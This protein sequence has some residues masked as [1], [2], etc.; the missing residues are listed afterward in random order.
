MFRKQVFLI[1]RGIVYVIKYIEILGNY[2]IEFLLILL[3]K[4]HHAFFEYIFQVVSKV[5]S[6]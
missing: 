5:Y 6:S 1:L 4:T 2:L 3:K